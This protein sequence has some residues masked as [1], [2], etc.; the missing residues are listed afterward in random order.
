[1]YTGFYLENFSFFVK[2]QKVKEDTYIL[3]ITMPAD[4]TPSM[5]MLI[6]LRF[7]LIQ[8]KIRGL[9]PLLPSMILIAGLAK[10]CEL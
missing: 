7:S 6:Q 9:G 5:A 1:L 3:P 4:G 8:P 2:P 10:T